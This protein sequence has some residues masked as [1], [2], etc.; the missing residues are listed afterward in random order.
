[1]P[2]AAVHG[3]RAPIQSEAV[4]WIDRARALVRSGSVVVVDY[5]APSTAA[6]AARPWRDWLRTYRGH[7][8]G[9]HPLV[10]PG[11]QDITTEVALDQL[12]EPDAVRSQSQWLQL[13]GIEELVAE[14]KRVWTEQSARPGLEA[15]RMRSR[16]S[17]SEALLD[18][19]GLGAFTVAE[20]RSP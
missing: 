12:P 13:W 20:W 3:A 2:A 6:L 8:R 11:S 16:V 9:E 19:S 18:R 5:T 15:I 10:A 4:A 14:G 7:V 1:V 17:E